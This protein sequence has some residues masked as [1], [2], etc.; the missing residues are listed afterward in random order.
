[1]F[2]YYNIIWVHSVPDLMSMWDNGVEFDAMLNNLWWNS[3]QVN[4]IPCKNV[5]ILPKQCFGI[6]GN[7][8]NQFH[9]QLNYLRILVVPKLR[10]RTW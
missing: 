7:W 10:S 1:M 4:I 6:C 3:I 8:F 5:L 9:I 2:D